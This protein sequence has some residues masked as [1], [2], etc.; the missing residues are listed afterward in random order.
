LVERVGSSLEIANRR[1][2][3]DEKGRDS[4]DGESGEDRGESVG[5]I[6]RRI[7]ASKEKDCLGAAE[8]LRRR[9]A[10]EQRR[11]PFRDDNLLAR[12]R[13][14]TSSTSTRLCLLNV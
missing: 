10:E 11:S 8:D 6:E 14:V 7:P 13:S 4:G 9:E 5:L 1:S 3:A 2:F 12:K